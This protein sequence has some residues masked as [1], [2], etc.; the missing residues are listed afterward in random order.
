MIQPTTQF[1][2]LL[3]LAIS[4]FCWGS[5]ANTFKV[6]KKWRFEHFYYDFSA[7]ILLTT[8]VAAFT[9]GTMNPQDLTFQD[10][11]LLAAYRKMAWALASG[12]V[13][14]LGNIFLLAATAFCGMSVA[15]PTALGIALVAGAIW[16][17]AYNPQA[18]ILLVFGGVVLVIVGIV[19][20]ITAYVWRQDERVLAATRPLQADPRSA[21]RTIVNPVWRGVILAVVAGLA[22]SAFVPT[23]TEATAGETGVSP[24]GTGLLL[25]SAAFGSTMLFVPFFLFFPVLGE[26]GQ[27]RGY[28]KGDKKQHALG[29]FG[30]VLL[31]AGVLAGLLAAGAPQIMQPGRP[32]KYALDHA[33]LLVAAAWGL[34]VWR[35]FKGASYRVRL[36][37]AAMLV[38]VVAGAGMIAVAPLYGK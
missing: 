17:F 10:N 30:G 8:L 1:T 35:E 24:Y 13:F 33:A 22:L 29:I 26:P 16:D 21:P 23:L 4:A 5:W 20:N 18:S 6:T 32:A 34:L 37:L 25:S 19:T 9:L 3:L 38:L 28:F 7:G 31:G 14:N 36:M 27:I 11:F 15:F 2:V 12:L